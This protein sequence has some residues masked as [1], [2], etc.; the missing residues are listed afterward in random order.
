MLRDK[1][2]MTSAQMKLLVTPLSLRRH[3]YVT[4][5]DGHM[6][7]MDHGQEADPLKS[8][9]HVTDDVA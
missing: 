2:K 5:P 8:N 3:I 7:T 4:M 1:Q 9:G 6:V